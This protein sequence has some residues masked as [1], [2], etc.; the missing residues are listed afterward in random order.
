MKQTH[1]SHEVVEFIPEH[2][3]DGTLYI[4]YKYGTA[5]HKCACGCAEEVVTPLNPTDWS[6]RMDANGPTLH[7]SIGNWSFACRS[8]YLIRDGGVVWAKQM[9]RQQIEKGRAR[10]RATKEAYFAQVNRE[11]AHPI[12]GILKRVRDWLKRWWN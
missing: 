6:I 2:L 3:K 7:P 4:S 12:V 1:F 9:T 8:H 11:R 10:D 5:V